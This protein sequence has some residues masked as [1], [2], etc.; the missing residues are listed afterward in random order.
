MS[1]PE[2][3]GPYLWKSIHFIALG[4]PKNPCIQDKL[5]FKE[6]FIN[7]HKV[8]PCFSCAKNYKRHLDELPPID[9]YLKSNMTLFEWTWMLHNIVNKELGKRELSFKD[10]IKL[11]MKPWKESFIL[12]DS[13]IVK[14]MLFT[15]IIIAAVIII[16]IKQR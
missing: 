1:S 9:N 5:D 2:I 8:I 12:D 13:T 4:Y 6:F 7:L 10:A 16:W 14:I 11:Y 3:W 15:S